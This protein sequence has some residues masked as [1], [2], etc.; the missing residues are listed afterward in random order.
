M[1][2]CFNV[3]ERPNHIQYGNVTPSPTREGDKK[4]TRP[5]AS[6]SSWLGKPSRGQEDTAIIF[7]NHYYTQHS[8]EGL[9]DY[10]KATNNNL[11][12]E[13]RIHSQNTSVILN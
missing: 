13:N 6:G 5:K 3:T 4:R 9:L 11:K 7:R 2:I 1:V 12:K 10:K 8:M